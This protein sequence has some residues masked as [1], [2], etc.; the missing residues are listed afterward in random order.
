MWSKSVADDDELPADLHVDYT[1]NKEKILSAGGWNYAVNM[2]A[3][4]KSLTY[5]LIAQKVSTMLSLWRTNLWSDNARQLWIPAMLIETAALMK[6][7]CYREPR[8]DR[9]SL[10]PSRWLGVTMSAVDLPRIL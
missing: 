9:V 1:V 2:V 6:W 5:V 8:N 7:R 3:T 4:S 10:G